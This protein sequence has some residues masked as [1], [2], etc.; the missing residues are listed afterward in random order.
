[1]PY[2]RAMN[3]TWIAT[4]GWVTLALINAGLAEQKNR[5][6]VVWFVASLVIGPV[7]TALIV[8]QAPAPAPASSLPEGSADDGDRPG[9]L[10]LGAGLVLVVAGTVTALAASAY[11]SW[12]LWTLA[13]VGIVAGAALVVLHVLV[14]RRE[15]E[16]DRTPLPVAHPHD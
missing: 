1:M 11:A 13:A 10:L 12:I 4:W 8:I 7:A 14:R 3:D 9:V 15:R 16:L 5:S 6:R 2:G